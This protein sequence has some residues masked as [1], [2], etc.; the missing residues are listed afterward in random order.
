MWINRKDNQA[1]RK[2]SL[3]YVVTFNVDL[4]AVDCQ[5]CYVCMGGLI[6]PVLLSYGAQHLCASF[7]PESPKQKQGNFMYVLV[8]PFKLI[9]HLCIP[10]LTSSWSMYSSTEKPSQPI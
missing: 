4:L 2:L 6:L 7:Y 9:P 3:L 8:N 10:C 5:L 1:S